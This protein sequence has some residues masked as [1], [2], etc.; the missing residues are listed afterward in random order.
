MPRDWSRS[1]TPCSGICWCAVGRCIGLPRAARSRAR[2]LII[3]AYNGRTASGTRSTTSW[4]SITRATCS[5]YHRF[6]GSND[7]PTAWSSVT[8]ATWSSFTSLPRRGRRP[9]SRRGGGVDGRDPGVL[10][11]QSLYATDACVP[12]VRPFADPEVGGV[13]GNQRYQGG[14]G[15]EGDGEGEV[16]TGRSNRELKRAE[17]NGGQTPSPQPERAT[18]SAAPCSCR[19]GRRHRR[20]RDVDARDR[21]RQAPGIRAG[22][23]CARA[24]GRHQRLEFG[25]RCGS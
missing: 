9:S 11:R 6:G 23:D 17:S 4:P 21:P 13:A 1:R 12:L 25:A 22:G 8:S 19:A 24:G 3:A 7:G 20:F 14:K 15:A 5:R 2:Q 10:R 18:R 16:R